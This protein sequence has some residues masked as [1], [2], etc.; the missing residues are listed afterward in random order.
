MARNLLSRRTAL[1]LGP[2]ALG[3]ASLGMTGPARA[4]P[5]AVTL[6]VSSSSLAYGG[7]QI[8][9][10][11]GLF[12]KHGLVP[13]LIVMSS[14]NAAIAAVISNSANFSGAGAGEVLA[15]RVRGQDVV[16][17]SN[18]YHGLSGSVVLAKSV[19]EKLSVHSN[20]P[21]EDRLKALD[22]LVVAAPS[23]TS[24][25]LTP[26]KS[27]AEAVGSH[28]KFVYMTQPAMVAALQ[29]GAIQGISAGAPFSLTPVV[30]GFGVLWISGPKGELPAAARP[31]SSACLQ[32][33]AAYARAHPEIMREMHAVFAETAK[34]IRDDPDKARALLAKAY[35][36]L[37]PELLAAAFAESA[38][39]WSEP[40]MTVA[41]IRQEISIQ[42]NA[43][44]L[45]GVD[46]LDPAAALYVPE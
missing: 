5:L 30:K 40:D 3:M 4:E 19:A 37:D 36:T 20:A 27:A 42:V 8:A 17:V 14:G 10:E 43:K 7:L 9:L 29:T 23:A 22:G 33:S 11:S 13:R 44:A 38:A 41:D 12:Q 39:N 25:Y 2:A 28:P 45:P 35:P 15:A 21:V 18:I 32:T 46:K 16:I 24:A 34:L 6:A 1:A 26:L 31:T